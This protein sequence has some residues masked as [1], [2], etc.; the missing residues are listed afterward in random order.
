MTNNFFFKIIAGLNLSSE[1]LISR[2]GLTDLHPTSSLASSE[3]HF[4]MEG[5]R[6]NSPR[7]GA[8]LRTT[9]SRKRAL[10][11]S[12][13]SDSFD[14][15]SM[16]R[17]SPNSLAS[18]VNGS[19]SSS[20]SGS[21]GHLSA[22]ALSPALSL[23]PG[24]TPHLQQLQA[25]LFRTAGTSLLH[26]LP[27]TISPTSSMFTLSNHSH[28]NPISKP[29][30]DSPHITPDTCDTSKVVTLVEADSASSSSTLLKRNRRCEIIN[31]YDHILESSSN[32]D[33]NNPSSQNLEYSA[34]DTTDL[35]DEPGDFIETNCHWIDCNLEFNTQDELVKHINNDH[36]HANKKSFICRWDDCSREE[37]PFK[38]QYMLVVHMRRHTGEKPHKCTV[39]LTILNI[40]LIKH[41]IFSNTV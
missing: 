17:F 10:S 15:N 3:F 6:I 21:Y 1:Y 19:R 13:Y 33:C 22:S 41:F 9:V 37:K 7:H 2:P 36:I 38:A 12:P 14:I 34:V 5:S 35:K 29:V 25:H 26:S 30:V 32:L 31:K 11:S 40:Y 16:I 24:M 23:H 4:S 18:I 8:N 27:H 39:S 20:A 28:S